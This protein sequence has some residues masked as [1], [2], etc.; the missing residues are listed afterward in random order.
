MAVKIR[1]LVRCRYRRDVGF[2]VVSDFS[3]AL[4]P[5]S[6]MDRRYAGLRDAIAFEPAMLQHYVALGSCLVCANVRQS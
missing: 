5:N 1:S 3:E 2:E 4:F 6:I